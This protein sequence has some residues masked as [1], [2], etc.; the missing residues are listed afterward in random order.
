MKMVF[1]FLFFK[2]IYG[3]SDGELVFIEQMIAQSYIGGE[4][5]KLVKHG[6]DERTSFPCYY[7]LGSYFVN[8]FYIRYT[9]FWNDHVSC[10][11]NILLS[12]STCSSG[13]SFNSLNYRPRLGSFKNF[14]N[15][16][17]SFKSELEMI[18][19]AF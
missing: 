2:T 3:V 15:S 6:G 16:F 4:G 19:L 14:W 8:L 12:S 7:Y 10:S 17:S 9:N 11:E 1:R 13:E 18:K 5:K